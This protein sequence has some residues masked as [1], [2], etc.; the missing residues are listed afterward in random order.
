[1]REA[2]CLRERA[3]ER[4]SWAATARVSVLHLPSSPLEASQK[5]LEAFQKFL[6]VFQKLL[7]SLQKLLESFQK[8]L[9][10]TVERWL[11]ILSLRRFT[12]TWE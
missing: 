5:F 12:R 8:R 3:E 9:M 11:W 2:T 7:E 6:E 1:M 4:P 10:R